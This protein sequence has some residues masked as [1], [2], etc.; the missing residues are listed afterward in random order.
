MKKYWDTEE[1]KRAAIASGIF[2][3]ALLLIFI[4]FGLS[5]Y[6]PK[7]ENGIVINFGNSETGFGQ[8]ADGAQQATPTPPKTQPK[9]QQVEQTNDDA[10][11]PIQTQDVTDAPAVNTQSSQKVEAQETQETTEPEE[12]NPIHVSSMICFKPLL[13]PKKEAKV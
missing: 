11:D 4:F 8:Q 9:S 12:V 10:V 13:T 1:K 5:Y 2:H 6:D 7:P 3:L